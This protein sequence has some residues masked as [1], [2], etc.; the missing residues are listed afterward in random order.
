M[1]KDK[2]IE[3]LKENKMIVGL[4]VGTL[5]LAGVVGFYP[6][7]PA[8][9]ETIAQEITYPN[10]TKH[11]SSNIEGEAAAVYDLETGQLIF[12]VNSEKQL[13]LASITKVMTALIARE[14]LALGQTITITPADLEPL[15]ESGFFIGE[16]WKAKDLI[17]YTLT[18]SS[19]DGAAAL[20]RATAGDIPTFTKMMND[21]AENLGL[22][23]TYFLNPTGL[24]LGSYN[25]GAYGTAND[26]AILMAYIS[27]TYP[28]L[29]DSTDKPSI[30]VSSLDQVAHYGAN[31]NKYTGSVPGLLASKTGFTDLAGGNLAIL[32]DAGLDQK[33]AIVVLGSSEDG[34]FRD[35]KKLSAGVIS[36]FVDLYELNSP[37]T[38]NAS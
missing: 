32:M 21:K 4:A 25:S 29:M 38:T 37:H 35:I 7:T 6:A 16:K 10:A 19:N 17:D 3:L 20:A 33:V 23:N 15:G 36:W 28:D 9:A 13:P 14:N 24:D 31:T 18:T 11:F 12:S 8:P 5:V 30:K 1:T 27:K 34:R 22:S 2:L 26:I